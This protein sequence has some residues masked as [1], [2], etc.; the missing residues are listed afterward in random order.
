MMFSR[1]DDGE[2]VRKLMHIGLG[3]ILG[4]LFYFDVLGKISLLILFGFVTLMFFV[5]LFYK[6]PGLHQLMLIVERS[7]DMKR[8]PGIG[9]IYFVLGFVLSAWL[10]PK[11]IAVASMMVLGFGDA[12]TVLVGAYGQ[13]PFFNPLKNW[14]GVLAAAFASSVAASF[15]VPIGMAII[16]ATVSMLVEGFD[17]AVFGFKL[18]DNVTV[19]V[20]CGTVLV[21]LQLI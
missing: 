10:F 7:R 9:A 2:V 4:L 14:E 13:I 6:I 19:P 1:I 16:A 11:N 8:F 20:V 17:V 3:I 15:F 21:L 5:Y 12:V 18:N